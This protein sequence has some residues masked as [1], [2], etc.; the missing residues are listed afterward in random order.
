M[1]ATKIMTRMTK[2][3]I[4]VV[5][6]L[7]DFGLN[8]ATLPVIVEI[9]VGGLPKRL[10]N[11]GNEQVMECEKLTMSDQFCVLCSRICQSYAF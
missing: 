8:F 9:V 7:P 2:F 5:L 10:G 11:M 6:R 4:L 1:R 3:C